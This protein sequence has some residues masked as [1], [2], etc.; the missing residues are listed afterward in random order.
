M[1]TVAIAAVSVW[2]QLVFVA[3]LLALLV[4]F[5]PLPVALVP[6][7]WQQLHH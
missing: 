5:E 3:V 2:Q 4:A 1:K 6:F 7:V